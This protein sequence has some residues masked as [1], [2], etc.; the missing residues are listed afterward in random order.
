MGDALV[1]PPATRITPKIEM[2]M[3]GEKQVSR[4]MLRW[5][6][7]AKDMLPAWAMIYPYLLHVEEQLFDTEGASGKNG[8]WEQITQE[9][10]DRKAKLGLDPRILHATL[11]LRDALTQEGNENQRLEMTPTMMLFGVKS[12]LGY[13]Y[14]HQ[15]P[16][17]GQKQRRAIDLTETNKI[18]IL[19]TIQ[20]WIVGAKWNPLY[21]TAI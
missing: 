10:V 15:K 16:Q 12:N 1:M 9:W 7:R 21:G 19:K 17:Q 5:T 18:V 20:S 8:S 3:L 11:A 13:G 6:L 14:V 4:T 2:I